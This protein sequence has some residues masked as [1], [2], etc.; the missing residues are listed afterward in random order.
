[1]VDTNASTT[2]RKLVVRMRE[3]L[4]LREEENSFGVSVQK[5]F[6]CGS[7]HI[8]VDSFSL[9]KT[10]FASAFVSDQSES[11]ACVQGCKKSSS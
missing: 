3:T 1:M 7:T 9:L 6:R 11:I 5:S 4:K 2:Q 10:F 8:F